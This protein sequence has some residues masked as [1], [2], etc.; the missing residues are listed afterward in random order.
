MVARSA[1]QDPLKVFNYIVEVEGFKRAGFYSA[2]GLEGTSEVDE[3]AEGGNNNT[4]Q[5]S[6]GRASYGNITLQRGQII[7]PDGEGDNDFYTW[8]IQIHSIRTDG[9]AD[10]QYRRDM[11]IV[12]YNRDGTEARRWPV[13]QCWPS[14]YKAMSDLAG[15]ETGNS[16][17]E[18]EIVQE[19]FEQEDGP[20]PAG[21]G[22]SI[23][24]SLGIGS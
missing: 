13:A 17:E 20:Q 21:R 2:T 4:N 16:I 18:M 19:G 15:S 5:K 3:Y 14:R 9:F 7:D 8:W 24:P 6:P 23:S 22:Q 10:P 12:Q 11:T 1:F